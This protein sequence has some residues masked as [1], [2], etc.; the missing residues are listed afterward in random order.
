MIDEDGSDELEG[1]WWGEEEKKKC[2]QMVGLIA[3]EIFCLKSYLFKNQHIS[4]E[5]I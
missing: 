5:L 2:M 4:L 1:F 3:K